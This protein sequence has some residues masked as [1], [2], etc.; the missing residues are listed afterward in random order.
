MARDVWPGEQ[1]K[2]G[3]VSFVN[4]FAWSGGGE[5]CTRSLIEAAPHSGHRLALQAL[6]PEPRFDPIDDVEG[7]LLVDLHNLPGLQRRPDRRLLRRVPGRA[8]HRFGRAL[9]RALREPYV[10]LDNAYVDTCDRPYLPCGG[11]EA[12]SRCPYKRVGRC[13]RLTGQPIYEGAR[14]SFFVSPLHAR[15][16]ARL[17]PDVLM[18]T[19]ILRPNF[20]PRPF[21]EAGQSVRDIEHLYVGT[22]TEAKGADLL[23]GLGGLTVVTPR[24]TRVDLPDARVLVG[25]DHGDMPAIYGRARRFVFRAR[26]PEPF[27]RV[28]AEAALAGCELVVEG[29]IG[30]LSF[31]QHPADLGLYERA[32]EEFWSTTAEALAE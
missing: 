29:E 16:V 30:A 6:W 25:V 31:E 19:S 13:H 32:N 1:V 2:I 7:W 10:H 28:V 24:S 12:F 27:G 3:V 22:I 20:D 11:S 15:T 5:L 17:Q 8:E 9:A 14:R 18:K 26:W 21:A 23:A 4:P